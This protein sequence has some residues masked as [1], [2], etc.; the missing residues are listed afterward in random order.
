MSIIDAITDREIMV[1]KMIYRRQEKDTSANNRLFK[2]SPIE[3]D[4]EVHVALLEKA[5]LAM[6]QLLAREFATGHIH[7]EDLYYGNIFV[8]GTD[9]VALIDW[10]QASVS[11]L[12]FLGR[13]PPF[14]AMPEKKAKVR[15][16]KAGEL[17]ERD[18]QTKEEQEAKA[19]LLQVY[20]AATK[21]ENPVLSDVFEDSRTIA[22]AKCIEFATHTLEGSLIPLRGTLQF[23][24]RYIYTHTLCRKL[25]TC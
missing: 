6:Q 10:Q 25:T 15:P 21:V 17:S 5:G 1:A 22:L 8:E 9:V 12:Q 3:S 23:I 14:L 13:D 2:K 19:D 11:P 20:R 24:R 4:M 7:H 16:S 18:R